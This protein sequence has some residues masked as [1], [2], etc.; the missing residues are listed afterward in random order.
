MTAVFAAFAL[1]PALAL[2]SFLNVVAARV[3]RK[4]SVV[5]PRSACPKCATELAWYDNVPVVSWLVLRGRCRTC[6]TSIAATYPLVELATALLVAG[7][8]LRF[9]L[10]PQAA[11]AAGFC[12]VL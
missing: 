12:A 9:G 3:P 8:V 7:C 11:L 10:T 1:G 2:G 6:D 5:H 4:R